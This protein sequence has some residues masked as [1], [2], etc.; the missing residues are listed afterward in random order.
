MIYKSSVQAT[1]IRPALVEYYG[2]S[3]F[4]IIGVEAQPDDLQFKMKCEFVRMAKTLARGPQGDGGGPEGERQPNL[5][6]EAITV[7][8]NGRPTTHNMEGRTF[9]DRGIFQP[10]RA[11]SVGSGMFA[12]RTSMRRS[13][14]PAL[15][16]S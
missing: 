5:P 8:R 1:S 10:C 16:S 15:L 14:M 6:V 13:A 9:T 7:C 2:R 3:G 4:R 12:E 11:I